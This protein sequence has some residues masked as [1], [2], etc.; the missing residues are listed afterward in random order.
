MAKCIVIQIMGGSIGKVCVV[1]G[2]GRLTYVVEV[3][4]MYFNY[5]MVL[6]GN[7]SVHNLVAGQQ[8]VTC[9]LVIILTE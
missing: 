1:T 8:N 2:D 7:R 5:P 4:C 9:V 3:V 6:G